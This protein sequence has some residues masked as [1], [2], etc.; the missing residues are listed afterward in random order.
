MSIS[1]SF[2]AFLKQR[3]K[4]LNNSFYEERICCILNV[5]VLHFKASSTQGKVCKRIVKR[6]RKKGDIIESR[7]LIEVLVCSVSRKA[8]AIPINKVEVL[9]CL[10]GYTDQARTNVT[11]MMIV[12]M[13]LFYLNSFRRY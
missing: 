9:F 1:L 10:I 13:Q 11:P 7:R 12:S 8:A 4:L 2:I 3:I 5:F 6:K